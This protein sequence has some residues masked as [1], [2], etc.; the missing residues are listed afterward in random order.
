VRV[1]LRRRDFLQQ[2]GLGALA[3]AAGPPLPV[4]AAGPGPRRQTTPSRVLVLGAG[5]SGLAAAYELSRAGHEVTVLEA[6]TRVGG[7]V[8]TLREG[9]ADDL[10][11]EAGATYVP[12]H[13]SYTMHY[14]QQLGVPIDPVVLQGHSVVYLAGHR[15]RLHSG[16][17]VTW[18]VELRTDER[19]LDLTDLLY[20][21]LG[22]APA[23]VGDPA[24][25]GW[26]TEALAP[27]DAVSPT[28]FFRAQGASP[29]ALS[30][31]RLA[32]D[33]YLQGDGSDSLSLLWALRY[34]HDLAATRQLHLIRGGS[35]RLPQAFAARLGSRIRLGAPVVRLEH[36]PDQ[37]AVTYL[38]SGTPRALAGD[39]LVCSI[40]FSVLRTL[41]VSPAFSP[42]KMRAIRELPYTSV[43]RVYLQVRRRF[44]EDQE[45]TGYATTDLP[46]MACGH[47]TTN[48]PG[49]RGILTSYQAGPQ[50]RATATLSESDRLAVTLREMDRVF[51]G[52][53]SQYEWG[54]SYAWDL[55]PWARGAY[56]WVGPGQLT[57]LERHIRS[58]EGRVYFAGEHASPWP[59]WMQGALWSGARV[60]EAIV[61]AP[62]RTV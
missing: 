59:G 37:V 26:P 36:T 27:Y 56:S 46:I 61:N 44:W 55:D 19:G 34:L 12:D 60:A 51:P 54:T 52:A 24:A 18:P 20:H 23:N 5:L 57:G 43:T 22:D 38:D 8:L 41:E 29:G 32:E 33:L 53:T 47:L 42:G 45:E 1:R 2:A 14:L 4:A 31:L 25:A 6:R 28:A 17:P 30:L 16:S 58:P 11:A 9:F 3:L 15:I 39:Y 48:Q 13:H 40:P 21:Y 50:A 62:W 10:Y 49:P 35:D 7:R